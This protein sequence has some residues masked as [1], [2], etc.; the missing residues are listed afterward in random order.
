MALHREVSRTNG[1][2]VMAS[3]T[4]GR[5]GGGSVRRKEQEWLGWFGQCRKTLKMRAAGWKGVTSSCGY[6]LVTGAEPEGHPS[7]DTFHGLFSQSG[8]SKIWFQATL[9]AA[10]LMRMRPWLLTMAQP[11]QHPPCR[12]S[13]CRNPFHPRCCSPAQLG[14]LPGCSNNS[15][16]F[17]S[18]RGRR[19]FLLKESLCTDRPMLKARTPG[20]VFLWL[21][22]LC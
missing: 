10:F 16:S 5:A 8:A 19:K 7:G 18:E 12:C 4:P 20:G 21:M 9:Q 22:L 15:H 11:Q 2:V 1:W 3:E 6:H 14:S 17:F 13:C